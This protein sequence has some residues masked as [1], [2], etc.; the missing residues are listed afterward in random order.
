MAYEYGMDKKGKGKRG[1]GF[2]LRKLGEWET[3]ENESGEMLMRR[4]L[5]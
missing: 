5:T 4:L 3:A 1:E 2:W